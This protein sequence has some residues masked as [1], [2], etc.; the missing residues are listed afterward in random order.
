MCSG[1]FWNFYPS[2]INFHQFCSGC[3]TAE[4]GVGWRWMMS[5]ESPSSHRRVQKTRLWTSRR[6]FFR[7]PSSSGQRSL[8]PFRS[9]DL[10]FDGSWKLSVWKISKNFCWC[11]CLLTLEPLRVYSKNHWTWPP[12]PEIP[13]QFGPFDCRPTILCFS[14]CGT[15]TNQIRSNQIKSIQFK[16]TLF[17]ILQQ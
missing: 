16:C 10:V 8:V 13:L 7:F 12:I 14:E 15:G 2:S 3:W 5:Q 17:L 6:S 1:S 11:F 9:H 4:H